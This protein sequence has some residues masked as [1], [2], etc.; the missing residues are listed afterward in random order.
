MNKRLDCAIYGSWCQERC[1]YNSFVDNNPAVL[2]CKFQHQCIQLKTTLEN[3]FNLSTVITKRILINGI[4][5][6]FNL[7]SL[8]ASKKANASRWQ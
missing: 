3:D 1:K 6:L 7:G 5:N 2:R 4:P 8:P